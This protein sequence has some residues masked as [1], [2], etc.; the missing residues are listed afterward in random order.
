MLKLWFVIL[1]QLDDFTLFK[2]LFGLIIIS[3]HCH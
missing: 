2:L 1:T 3:V